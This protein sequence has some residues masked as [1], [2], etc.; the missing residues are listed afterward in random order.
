MPTD[1]IRIH[2]LY[3]NDNVQN[4]KNFRLKDNNLSKFINNLN[5]NITNHCL[6]VANNDCNTSSLND[7]FKRISM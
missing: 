2:Y 6:V 5:K 3:E 7:N 4:S 1:R